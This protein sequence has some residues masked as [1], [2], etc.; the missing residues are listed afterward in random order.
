LRTSRRG[1][2][3]LELALG[4]IVFVTILLFGIHFAE[5]GWLSLKV[6]EAQTW[7]IWEATGP[8]VQRL[9]TRDTMPFDNTLATLGTRATANYGDFDGRAGTN[10]SAVI[11]QALTRASGMVVECREGPTLNGGENFAPSTTIGNL[12]SDRGV[13]QCTANAEIDP[14]RVPIRF[15]QQA[16]NGFF[17]AAH[18]NPGATRICGLGPMSGA[19][20]AGS[21]NILTNEN[22]A[23]PVAATGCGLGAAVYCNAV[24]SMY[25]F[26]GGAAVALANTFA[27]HAP[28]SPGEYNFAYSGE[29]SNYLSP[30]FGHGP[31]GPFNT[32]SPGIGL[33]PN[34]RVAGCFLGKP[35]CP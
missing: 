1:Q 5:F 10:G 16:N 4:S 29:E 30:T 7:A 32:G 19:N 17:N 28:A 12:Y 3:T 25:G 24:Q 18:R 26:G 22:G 6:Q 23:Q 13:V 20:C 9:P 14:F 11:T 21:L 8:R 33:V 34:P 15:L 31:A 2:A 35:G 27:G